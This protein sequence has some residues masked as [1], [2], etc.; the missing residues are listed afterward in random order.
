LH[1]TVRV[2]ADMPLTRAF[3]LLRKRGEQTAVVMDH[4]VRVVGLLHIRDIA[5][6]IVRDA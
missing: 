2:T 6:Y 4:S 5:R 3:R 1:K